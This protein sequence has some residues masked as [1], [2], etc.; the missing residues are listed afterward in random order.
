MFN[1]KISIESAFSS[2]N[3]IVINHFTFFLLTA[4]MGLLACAV[5]LHVVGVIDFLALRH[6]VAPL[7]K[8]FQN[9]FASATSVLHY[10]DFTVKDTLIAYLPA[11]IS[12]QLLQKDFISF[13]IS[14]YD[15]G[16]I[17]SWILPSALALK[18]FF[19]MISVGWM[20]IALDLNAN[21]PVSARYLYQY[22][23]FVP[24]VFVVDLL[25]FAVTLLGFRLFIIPGIFIYQRLRFARYFVVDKNL[26]IVKAFQASWALTDG[27]VLQLFGFSLISHFIEF[28][29]YVFVFL[30]LYTIPLLNQA[31]VN[32]YTQ[33]SSR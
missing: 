25:L 30:N 20:K 26:G 12:D 27:S 32:V 4:G 9:A 11:E 18:L 8:M 33:L 14:G 29:G 17:L 16:Y 28:F 19:N 15:W 7:M 6:H 5:F 24:R 2:G 13:D 23:Y 3:R 22:Y 31:E 21:K 10:Q 1:K